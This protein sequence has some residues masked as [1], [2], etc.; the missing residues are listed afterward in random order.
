[1]K[2]WSQETKRRLKSAEVPSEKANKEFKT[3]PPEVTV[4]TFHHLEDSGLWS[5][6]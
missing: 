4:A 3:D 6:H 1:M 2:I 5:S